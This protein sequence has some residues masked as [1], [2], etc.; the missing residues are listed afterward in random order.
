[1]LLGNRRGLTDETTTTFMVTGTIHLL[2][3]SGLHVGMLVCGIWWLGRI[4][5]LSRRMMLL[6]AVLFV[7]G[8]AMLTEARPPVV[9]AAALV[10]VVCLARLLGRRAL[11]INT[12]AAAGIQGHRIKVWIN[13]SL[14]AF[15]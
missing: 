11:A 13:D 5:A 15:L 3:I 14:L 10:A 12:L 6:M 7:V 9:R 2:A 8:Y 4:G 1:M